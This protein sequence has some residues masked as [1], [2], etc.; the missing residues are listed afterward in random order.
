M[1]S[2]TPEGLTPNGIPQGKGG[3]GTIIVPIIKV[4]VAFALLSLDKSGHMV[5]LFLSM[6]PFL[7]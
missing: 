3:R 5:E 2:L 7:L 6:F 1:M 4:L